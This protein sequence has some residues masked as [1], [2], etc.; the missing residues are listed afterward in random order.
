MKQEAAGTREE[1]PPQTRQHDASREGI[2][3]VHDGEHV[4]VIARPTDHGGV[5]AWV[6]TGA[7]LRTYHQG[8]E[9]R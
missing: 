9:R 2:P 3:A 4:N 1:V 7:D 6:T 8:S 5:T